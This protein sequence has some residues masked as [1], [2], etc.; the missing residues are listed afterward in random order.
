MCCILYDYNKRRTI[1][2]SRENPLF[3]F[4]SILYS[5]KGAS[6]LSMCFLKVSNGWTN[7]RKDGNILC[8]CLQEKTST[9]QSFIPGYVLQNSVHSIWREMNGRRHGEEPSNA[10]R[11]IKLIDKNIRNRLSTIR[12][13]ARE[14]YTN[15]I[16]MWFGS[17]RTP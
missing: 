3:P 12:R 15:E 6:L 14:K 11:L 2:L 1:S 5:D 10:E 16:Q 17:R 8:W 7:I 4:V 13:E 9:P